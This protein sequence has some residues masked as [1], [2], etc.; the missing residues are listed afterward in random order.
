M[1]ADDDLARLQGVEHIVVLMMENRSFDHMLGYL[2]QAGMPVNGLT[3]RETNPDDAGKPVKV[4]EYP[5]D[6]TAF[7]KPGEPLDESLDPCHDPADVA[8]QLK[9][10]NKGFVKNF[11]AQKAPL[12]EHR[13]LPMGHF[14]ATHL[15]VYDFL[16]H[17]FC[18]CDAW[19]SSIPGDTMPNRCYSIA[20]EE[21]PSV[22]HE[23]DLFSH[24]VG[25]TVWSKLENIPVYDLKA[26]TRHLD[27]TQWRW[28][29]HDPATLRAVDG[30]YRQLFHL[31]KDNFAYFSKKTVSLELEAAEVLFVGGS[32]LDDAA[33]G[34][35]R[36]VS[37]IDPNFIDLQI[38]DPTG[39]DDHPP[40]DIH[41]G[42]G[43]VLDLFQALVN[44]PQWEDTVL[45]IT[46]DEHGGFY[47]HVVPPPVPAG[48]GGRYKTYGV[49]VP[50]LVI[51][52]RVKNGV[53]STFFDHT[54]LIS[55]ILRRFAQHPDQA[56]AAMPSRVRAAEHVGACLLDE[57]RTD[58]GPAD[59]GK[60]IAD[61]HA[62]VGAW[63]HEAAAL[64]RA[65]PSARSLAP[66]GAG[67]PLVLHDFQEQFLKFALTMRR[68]GQPPG[69]P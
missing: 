1:A 62:K 38:F 64:R 9:G 56:L 4:F 33:N 21:G 13:N 34:K 51:G 67:H 14:T 7:H 66:D 10:G 31:S 53:C 35:L 59:L 24:L 48:D 52:P 15:P 32:F 63:K 44:S 18:V 41:A 65:Q 55:T 61:L 3:G 37:W 42:Q 43:L 40:S 25:S 49:R 57:P 28:Y 17:T 22:A 58:V 8:Q 39:D 11:I 12:P 68:L 54:S 20:G 30:R 5:P 60:P 19:H 69:R 47:D 27:H 46:Y 26:F 16:A 29:S 6:F 45:V 2:T 23:L 36:D 50:A